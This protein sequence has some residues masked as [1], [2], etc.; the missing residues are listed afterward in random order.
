VPFG[1]SVF[2]GVPGHDGPPRKK[3]SALSL[4]L[5]TVNFVTIKTNQAQDPKKQ[6][7]LQPLPHFPVE[8]RRYLDFGRM[9]GVELSLLALVEEKTRFVFSMV[10]WKFGTILT[11]PLETLI[12]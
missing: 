4:A 8:T 3:R 7:C 10:I 6:V 12:V 9:I 1:A 11:C 5:R 2:P